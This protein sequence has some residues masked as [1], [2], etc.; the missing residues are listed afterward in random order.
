MS[1]TN[2]GVYEYPLKCRVRAANRTHFGVQ[3]PIST[4]CT[5]ENFVPEGYIFCTPF[6]FLSLE[7]DKTPYQGLYEYPLKCRV[8]LYECP[9]LILV[10]VYEYP[11]KCQV[12]LYE[13]PLLILGSVYEYRLQF[14]VYMNNH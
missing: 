13:C 14:L 5:P 3:Y 4:F 6:R 2:S 1:I 11:L 10:S 7:C 9:L 12:S 8:S